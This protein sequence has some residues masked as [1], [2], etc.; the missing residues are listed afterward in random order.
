MPPFLAP[1]F[2]PTL[3]GW[4]GHRDDDQDD[5]DYDEELNQREA[6]AHKITCLIDARQGRAVEL[7]RFGILRRGRLGTVVLVDHHGLVGIE[8]AAA[9]GIEDL[10]Y[11]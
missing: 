8:R 7:F 9:A 2:A 5:G 1:A 10:G 4:D 3:V 11:G 6:A